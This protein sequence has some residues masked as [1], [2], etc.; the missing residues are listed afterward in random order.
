M[1]QELSTQQGRGGDRESLASRL[2]IV[3]REREKEKLL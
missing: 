1:E 2:P 3:K